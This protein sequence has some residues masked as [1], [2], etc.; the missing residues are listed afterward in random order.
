MIRQRV[1]DLHDG[2]SVVSQ[3][4]C[5]RIVAAYG[6][7][8]YVERR[9]VGYVASKFRAA[10]DQRLRWLPRGQCT[11]F[12]HQP[13]RC[14]GQANSLVLGYVGSGRLT[15]LTTFYIAT[16][17][18]DEIAR[19]K[20]VDFLVT[21]VSNHRISPALMRRWGWE[22]HCHSWRGRHYIKRFYGVYPTLP[23]P[24]RARLKPTA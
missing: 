5:G 19:L 10:W 1:P 3:W 2:A 8:Q 18:L 16:L 12:Y 9:R 6:R 21:E 22:P 23:E 11:L 15:S 20:G 4:R 17:A 14:C 7:L 24:L 13:W